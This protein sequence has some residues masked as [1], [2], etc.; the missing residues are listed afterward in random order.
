MASR[1]SPDGAPTPAK[2]RLNSRVTLDRP[3]SAEECHA[4]DR[5]VPVP[6]PRLHL[7]VVHGHVPQRGGRLERGANRSMQPTI[8][9]GDRILVDKLAYEAQWSRLAPAKPPAA[10]PHFAAAPGRPATWRYRGAGFA[11]RRRTPKT[12]DRPAG[13]EVATCCSSTA[14]QSAMRRATTAAPLP[15]RGSPRHS[16]GLIGSADVRFVPDASGTARSICSERKAESLA[17]D[18]FYFARGTWSIALGPFTV[19]CKGY[20]AALSQSRWV[21]VVTRSCAATG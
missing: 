2:L 6:Q 13:D 7:H 21:T 10:D 20:K 1:G 9:I 8:H 18:A 4:H 12:P 3:S 17:L 14:S 15:A 5:E 16:A 11:R 19:A